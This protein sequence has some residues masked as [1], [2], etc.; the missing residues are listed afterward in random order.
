MVDE[1]ILVRIKKLLALSE[2]PNP[3]EAAAA[4]AKAQALL[5]QHNLE[6]AQIEAVSLRKEG[7]EQFDW[8]DVVFPS[9]KST[10]WR[11]TL[12]G[13]VIQTTYCK[14]WFSHRRGEYRY[15]SIGRAKRTTTRR[16]VV[17]GR[18]A[19]VEVAKYLFI[20]LSRQIER[21]AS[22]HAK[23]EARPGV[24]G[25]RNRLRASFLKGMTDVV[26]WRLLEEWQDARKQ[27]E[28]TNA[29]MVVREGE[30]NEWMQQHGVRLGGSSKHY[31]RGADPYSYA[32]GAQAG[33]D[34][35]L[36]RGVSGGD[37]ASAKQLR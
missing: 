33:R 7:V 11:S 30:L 3:N 18:P 2:S 8:S 27:A 31:Y 1:A 23:A 6:L 10:E 19:D 26:Y 15:D 20:Y 32:R 35:S 14:A 36:T 5:T 9:N 12:F 17:I 28:Q 34:L 16:A 22:E 25:E 37:S 13:A 29:L 24:R 4:A 21:E